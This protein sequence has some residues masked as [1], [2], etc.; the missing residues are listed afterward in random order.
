[1]S[2]E[3]KTQ[4]EEELNN[5]KYLLENVYL[6]EENKPPNWIIPYMSSYHYWIDSIKTLVFSS[7]YTFI[8]NKIFLQNLVTF[9]EPVNIAMERKY[10]QDKLFEKFNYKIGEYSKY[11]SNIA[12]Y[13]Y[14][15]WNNDFKNKIHLLN[16]YSFALDSELTT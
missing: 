10:N 14:T 16:I 13:C 1:M 9:R 11:Q 2:L 7:I 6:Y 4:M 12:I 15:P 5:F 3:Q 8:S